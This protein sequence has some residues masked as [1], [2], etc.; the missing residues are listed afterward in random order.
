MLLAQVRFAN[1]LVPANSVIKGIHTQPALKNL[2]LSFNWDQVWGLSNLSAQLYATNVTENEI[3]YGLRATYASPGYYTV[4]PAD[5]RSYGLKLRY[6][7]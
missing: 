1:A 2:D 6:D 3:A 5:P 7:F 4:M